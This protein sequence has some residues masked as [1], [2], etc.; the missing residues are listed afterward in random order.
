MSF[1][2]SFIAAVAALGLATT[3]FAADTTSPTT[4]QTVVGT[5]TSTTQTATQTADT[6]STTTQDK[7]NINTATVKELMKVKGLNSARAKAIIA[8]RKK[9]GNFTDLSDLQ[10]VKGFKKL[11]QEQ[12]KT[13]QDQLTTG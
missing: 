12:L 11:K 6:Q 13:I 5:G 9:H 3:V 4:D 1:Y 7:L 8:Y 10:A 2:R